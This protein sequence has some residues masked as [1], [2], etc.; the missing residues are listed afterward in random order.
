M[1]CGWLRTEP[2]GFLEK[3]GIKL[4]EGMGS[5]PLTKE[6]TRRTLDQACAGELHY[7]TD[8]QRKAVNSLH[9]A[10]VVQACVI[11]CIT[12]GCAGMWENWLVL[13]YETDGVKWADAVLR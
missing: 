4:L 3:S 11:A 9:I 7:L 12:C 8:Q 10:C 6:Q 13:E 1:W 2:Q 5:V